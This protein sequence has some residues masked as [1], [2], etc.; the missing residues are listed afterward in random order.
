MKDLPARKKELLVIS[1]L[2]R[3]ILQLECAQLAHKVGLWQRRYDQVRGAW[4]WVAPLAGFLIARRGRRAGGLFARAA[5]FAVLARRVW[6]G[7]Q[8]LKG[9][10][11]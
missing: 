7:Y 11:Q 6:Q 5:S 1:D 9:K 10:R 8:A 3:Q 4:I 2:N